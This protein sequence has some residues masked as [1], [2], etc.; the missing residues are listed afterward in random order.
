MRSRPRTVGTSLAVSLE[1]W[2]YCQNVVTL[3]LFYRY[4]FGR[5]SSELVKLVPLPY[6][7]GRS[8]HY[9]DR[10]HEYSVTIPRYYKDVYV[11]S[12][13]P[14]TAKPCN[15]L[16]IKCFPLSC[17]WWWEL[18]KKN[19]FKIMTIPKNSVCTYLQVWRP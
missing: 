17:G 10:L 6:C 4:Y 18:L 3:S 2:A 19:V 16:S 5:C 9:S 1:T 11:N 8:T 14:H 12:F 15:S 13:F 7:Q